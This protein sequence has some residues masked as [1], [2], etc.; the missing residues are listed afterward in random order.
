MASTL[1]ETE[2]KYDD[3]SSVDEVTGK[4][5]R[6][7]LLYD[8][9][10]ASKQLLFSLLRLDQVNEQINGTETRVVLSKKKK[11]WEVVYLLDRSEQHESFY[12][13]LTPQNEYMIVHRDDIY[14]IPPTEKLS[15]QESLQKIMRALLFKFQETA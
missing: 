13:A 3:G 8:P 7:S 6:Q 14:S 15:V 10:E 11:N 5:S 12:I 1:L 2:Q 4:K 9:L